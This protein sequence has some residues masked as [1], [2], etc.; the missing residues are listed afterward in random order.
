MTTTTMTKA[1]ATT[2]MITT[3]TT[4]TMITTTTPTKTHL[5]VVDQVGHIVERAEVVVPVDAILLEG[6]IGD[7]VVAT[8]VGLLA[9]FGEDHRH[10]CGRERVGGRERERES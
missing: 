1:A 5:G 10:R 6:G 3:T 9:T 4:T 2:T 7:V 8:V